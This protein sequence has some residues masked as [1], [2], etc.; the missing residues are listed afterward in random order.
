MHLVVPFAQVT[1][2]L[3][4]FEPTLATESQVQFG[5]KQD[6]EHTELMADK[7]LVEEACQ[8]DTQV[9]LEELIQGIKKADS[10]EV[11]G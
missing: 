6:I 7:L 3:V 2:S 1:E 8:G 11:T 4:L 9:D 10:I 5:Q